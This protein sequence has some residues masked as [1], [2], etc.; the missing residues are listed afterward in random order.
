MTNA[1]VALDPIPTENIATYE[2]GAICT[3][4]F[5]SGKKVVSVIIC[6]RIAADACKIQLS[7]V[8]ILSDS[9][10]KKGHRT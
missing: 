1:K 10:C 4:N 6:R 2:L 5:R 3:F 7:S 9:D 8:P